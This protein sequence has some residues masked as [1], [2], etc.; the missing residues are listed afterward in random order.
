MRAGRWKKSAPD[1]PRLSGG[2]GLRPEPP[3]MLLDVALRR[4]VPSE[5]SGSTRWLPMRQYGFEP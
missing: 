1:A 5:A 2:S 4:E 3:T